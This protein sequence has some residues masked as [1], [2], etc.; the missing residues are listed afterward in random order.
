MLSSP[1]KFS[2]L[3][4]R[5]LGNMFSVL[6]KEKMILFVSTFSLYFLSDL[7]FWNVKNFKTSLLR[8]SLDIASSKSYLNL[9]SFF[10]D[11]KKA[12]QSVLYSRPHSIAPKEKKSN[13]PNIC[14]PAKNWTETTNTTDF[15]RLRPS[16]Q[17]PVWSCSCLFQGKVR[18]LYFCTVS[19]ACWE[20]WHL[21]LLAL[22]FSKLSKKGAKSS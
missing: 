4:V 2:G 16:S 3:K 5:P 6:K 18:V 19:L 20:R 1:K 17:F 10:C 12:F 21:L 9:K 8:M 13:C 22:F 15:S 14:F 11:S 7:P